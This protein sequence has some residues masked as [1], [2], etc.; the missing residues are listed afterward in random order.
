MAECILGKK[1][2]CL[3]GEDAASCRYTSKQS[4]NKKTDLWPFPQK[5]KQND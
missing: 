4:Q 1:C 2:K 5:V 3:T